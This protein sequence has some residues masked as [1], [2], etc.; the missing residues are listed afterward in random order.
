M[1]RLTIIVVV[2]ALFMSFAAAAAAAMRCGN[3]IVQEGTNGIEIQAECGDPVA[4]ERYF[5]DKYGEVDKWVY[6]PDAGYLYVI[7]L[8][9]G[10][11]VEIEEIQQ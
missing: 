2:L 6:G 4:K 5:I 8:F 1:Q 10:K 7:Y 3:L 9:M 11:V